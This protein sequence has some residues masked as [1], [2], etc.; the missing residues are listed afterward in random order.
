M[1]LGKENPS[2][3]PEDKR[4]HLELIQAVVTRMSVASSNAKSWLMPVVTAA[5][6]FALTSS[7]A[8]VAT[9]GVVAVL[10]FSYV[11]ANYLRQE[12]AYRKLYDVVALGEKRVP[13]FSLDTRHT[14]EP[15]PD[16]DE[17]TKKRKVAATIRRW[18]P[19]WN[20]WASWSIAPFYGTL[21]LLGIGVLIYGVIR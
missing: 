14:S 2:S 6:G 7:S 12:R 21:F 11:D 16:T 18:M 13:P 5:Y 15:L 20:I 19:S 4:K 10:L 3:D 8:A 1:T 9:L 17:L